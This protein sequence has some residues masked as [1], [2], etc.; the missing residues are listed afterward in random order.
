[1]TKQLAESQA[2]LE[3]LIGGGYEV[4]SIS[5]PFGEYPADESIL[6]SG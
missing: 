5:V 2:T 6:A 1:M 4:T 3:E